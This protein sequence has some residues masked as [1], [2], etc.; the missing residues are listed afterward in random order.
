MLEE[1]PEKHTHLTHEDQI[2]LQIN[3]LLYWLKLF[4]FFKPKTKKK[5]HSSHGNTHHVLA[6]MLLI[7]TSLTILIQE[8]SLTCPADGKQRTG[9]QCSDVTSSVQPPYCS[10]ISITMTNYSAAI[11]WCLL[12]AGALH[13][14]YVL[15]LYNNPITEKL[16]LLFYSQEKWNSE[17]VKNFL[18]APYCCGNQ[19]WVCH[20]GLCALSNNA[21][22]L[23]LLVV[24]G[25]GCSYKPVSSNKWSPRM[26]RPHLHLHSWLLLHSRKF[27]N[28]H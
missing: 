28:K 25:N 20:W 9:F 12:P 22:S 11:L 10:E 19:N 7:P 14:H 21:A 8:S 23:L 24:L 26:Q 13:T 27:L 5:S 16:F 2:P 4:F 18:I 3:R 17:R 15:K 6:S 1:L